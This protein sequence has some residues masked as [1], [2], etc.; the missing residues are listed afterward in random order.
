MAIASRWLASR[1]NK[2][3]FD[4]FDYN[5]YALMGDGDMMEGISDEA[6]SLAG[7]LGLS[8][9]CWIYDNNHVTIE[10]N[11]ALAFSED[12]ASVFAGY[13]WNV[14]QVKDANNLAM[15]AKAFQVFRD[16]THQPTLIIVDSHI[17]YGAPDIQDTSAAHGAPLGA[18]EI[19]KA[20]H[21]YG[22]PEDATFLIPDGVYEH[23]ADGIGARGSELREAWMALFADYQREHPELA[24]ELS[25]IHRPGAMRLDD[26]R[27]RLHD[28]IRM[29]AW[30]AESA[31]AGA[32]GA[33]YT[34]AEDEA[35]S[36]LAE[37]FSA[38]AD[39]EV[40]G[41]ELHVRLEAL[42][43]PRR[44]RAIASLCAELTATET[45]YPGTKLRLVYSV[46]GY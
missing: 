19:K 1:Y 43:A 35:H 46:K 21:S 17:G 22:W 9:L 31:L 29:A 40:K 13:G 4:L 33:H 27:K 6:A 38:S 28:A 14:T 45:L 32:L 24:A 44:S 16:E 39:L 20:K 8:N 12:V 11:T 25:A 3:G 41:D 37:A 42:S 10:G 23:F 36:L 26:E 7:H 15:L 30:N 5:V 34:R 2:P 18:E